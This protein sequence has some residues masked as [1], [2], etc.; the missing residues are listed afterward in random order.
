MTECPSEQAGT[1][2]ARVTGLASRGGGAVGAWAAETEGVE[3]ALKGAAAGEIIGDGAIVA[4]K[5]A[6]AGAAR[7]IEVA[8]EAEIAAGLGEER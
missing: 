1:R 8:H 7:A 2:G 6:V 4:D 5:A 3:E